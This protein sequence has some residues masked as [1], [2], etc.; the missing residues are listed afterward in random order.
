M[1][2]S[3]LQHLTDLMTEMQSVLVA[4][5]GG[6][7]SSLVFKVAY[8][9]LG[10]RAVGITAVS[11]TFP[12]VELETSRHIASEIGARHLVIQTDQLAIHAFVQNDAARCFH[13]KT[14]LYSALE[15]WRVELT[16]CH[17]VDGTNL[18]DLSD[19]R[20]GI[21]AAREWGVRSPLVEAGLSKADIRLL[22]KDLGLSNW[23]KPATACLSSRIPRGILITKEKLSRVEQAEAVLS[24]EGMKLFRVRDHGDTARIEIAGEEFS[25]VL[26]QERRIRIST[27]LKALGFRFVTLD[28]DG[29]RRGSTNQV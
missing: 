8:E 19:D 27:R 15:K 25:E 3:K 24:Q 2:P 16:L 10:Q 18:D 22:S 12:E 21:R 20:P 5:S 6:I 14:D 13:C 9:A 11:P 1:L 28:L 29:Y 7:D 17:I 26:N 4:F 23:D